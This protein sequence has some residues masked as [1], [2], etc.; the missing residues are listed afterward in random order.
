MDTKI[1][2]RGDTEA[3]WQRVNPVL[4]DKEPALS[5]DLIPMKVKY[6][7]GVKT[8][9]QLSYSE[10]TGTGGD[11]SSLALKD[12]TNVDET[13]F[14]NKGIASGLS[15]AINTSENK[16]SITKLD[17]EVSENTNELNRL[18]TNIGDES[19]PTYAYRGKNAPV[20]PLTS[21]QKYKAYYVHIILLS[22]GLQSISIPQNT[23]EGVVLSIENNDRTNALR[24]VPALGETINGS[25]GTFL[26]EKDTLNFFIKDGDDYKL[27]YGGVFPNSLASLKSTIQALL[28]NE[29]NTIDE[30][31][32]QLKDRLHTFKEIQTEFKGQLHTADDLRFEDG[33]AWAFAEYDFTDDITDPYHNFI[34][35]GKAIVDQET[36]I[37]SPSTDM[38]LRMR[39]PQ[40]IATLIQYV[41]T[42]PDVRNDMVK[43]VINYDEIKDVVYAFFYFTTLIPANTAIKLHFDF[44]N[45]FP[46]PVDEGITIQG[47]ET[48]ELFTG[49]TDAYYPTAIVEVNPNNSK[50]ALITPY[51]KVVV[52]SGLSEE[53]Q[54]P[55]EYK[56]TAIKLTDG[57]EAYSDPDA[58]TGVV[59]GIKHNMV[60]QKHNPGF[61]AYLSNPHRIDNLYASK[62]TYNKSVIGFMDDDIHV[63][64]D[65]VGIKYNKDTK[66]FGIEEYDGLD[67]NISN[68]TDFLTIFRASFDG[69]APSDGFLRIMLIKENATPSDTSEDTYI[70]NTNGLL[71]ADE[72]FYKQGDKL[73]ELEVVG[74]INVK[75]L[76]NFKCVVIT[77]MTGDDIYF[78]PK[79]NG[80]TGLMIQSI[81]S[82]EKTGLALL[83]YEND[84]QQDINFTGMV[85]GDERA[86][87]KY[88]LNEDS[89]SK[90][91]PSGTSNKDLAGWGY[92]A[93]TQN[94]IAISDHALAIDGDFSLHHI[95]SADE[96][97]ALRGKQVKV[98]TTLLNPQTSYT[99]ALAKHVEAPDD[100]NK[101]IF[102]S[103][104]QGGGVIAQG[105]WAIDFSTQQIIN[106]G[107]L[108]DFRTVEK[109]FTI[110]N[111]ANNYA[112]L[113]YPETDFGSAEIKLKE[114][115][116]DVVNPFMAYYIHSTMQINELDVLDIERYE[117]L[118][119][120]SQAYYSL[121]YTLTNKES[122]M[123]C[124]QPR[125][126]NANVV[127]DPT[128][129]VVQGSS[130]KGGEGALKFL[131]DGSVDIRTSIR[132][133]NEK[134]A[135][136]NARWWYAKVSTDGLTYTKID[137]SETTVLVSK[138]SVGT[139]FEM[140]PFRIDVES[141]DRIALRSQADVIDGAYIICT[142]DSKPM[143]TV[144]IDF[145]EI[146]TREQIF[147]NKVNTLDD[148]IVITDTAKA[149][150]WYIELDV[151]SDGKP[152]L[153]PKQRVVNP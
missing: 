115:K 64:A 6:G 141:G 5:T 44:Y 78:T 62:Q 30:I 105:G 37:T 136:Y 137:E 138:D 73:D 96:T 152:S 80:R 97:I 147:I 133:S 121:R 104:S 111:D 151:S 28:P 100:Y 58:E 146:T 144:K 113:I 63:P 22:D 125:F 76:L 8:W 55:A 16:A 18:K 1:Q 7:D 93:L 71:M 118:V 148:E 52:P 38:Y 108:T 79:E 51:V 2:L 59:M 98:S 107:S 88:D 89:P 135:N 60:E 85:L 132:I 106:S 142:D 20:L 112:I 131:L 74:A 46:K 81:T 119:Q 102:I 3:N 29:L 87:L 139:L 61:L 122:P 68:G 12:L 47:D 126:G 9:L 134:D 41:R 27:A 13:V 45:E 34:S 123:P 117:T 36:D 56:A 127:V 129:N 66:T 110:P 145:D 23:D 15:S 25:K 116:V 70:K 21:V 149:A 26:L 95:F 48:T 153:S 50:E 83:Q 90:I 143:L 42:G 140:K 65:G 53:P 82:H 114:F 72:K 86:T 67:P 39:L 11:T 92:Y 19:L 130:A 4:A 77:N 101:N 57:L 17:T 91:V 128:V 69:T 10:N 54:P 33:L 31:A 99:V 14:K 124:G 150:G 75:Q 43:H 94:N 103:R 24:L 84:T 35:L 49:V 32:A 120:N 109:I 40:Y